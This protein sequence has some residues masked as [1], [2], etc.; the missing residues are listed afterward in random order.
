MLEIFGCI[1]F[2]PALF[3]EFI[4]LETR[5]DAEQLAELVCADP[6]LAICFQSHGFQRGAGVISADRQE[7]RNEFVGHG[8]R[9]L[10]AFSLADGEQRVE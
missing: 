7:R 9:H 1:R 2:N 4:Q 10:H 5:G 8:Q 3:E 6:A